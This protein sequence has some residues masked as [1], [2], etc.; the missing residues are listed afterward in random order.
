MDAVQGACGGFLFGIPLLYTMEVW[1]IGSYTEPPLMFGVLAV[2]FVIVFALNRTDGFRQIRPDDPLHAAMDSVE[3]MAI[4]TVCVTCVLVLLREIS[5]DTS[6][7]EALGK[8]VLEGVP[9]AIG[10]ALARS[11]LREDEQEDG[12]GQEADRSPDAPGTRSPYVRNGGSDPEEQSSGAASQPR[13]SRT[14]PYNATLA[15]IGGTLV[16]TII[17]ASNIA[18][19]DEVPMLVAAASPPWLVGLILASLMV[20]YCIV[21]VA[22]FRTQKKRRQQPGIFQHPL[23]ETLTSYC[24]SLGAAMFMLWFFHKLT[25]DDPWALWMRYTIV[26]GLPACVGGAAGRLTV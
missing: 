13:N 19:T 20:S 26:L 14:T 22:G 10:V 24:I 6:L 2:T 9:F 18:P 5:L 21:F 3:A 11:L 7:D 16:G 17:I 4:G 15:D 23:T 12:D 1:W 8:I 25:F